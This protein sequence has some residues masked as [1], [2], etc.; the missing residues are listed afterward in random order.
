[1]PGPSNQETSSSRPSHSD[2]VPQQQGNVTDLLKDLSNQLLELRRERDEA[3][4]SIEK[5]SESVVV[6]GKELVE[7][8]SQVTRV[9]VPHIPNPKTPEKR[10]GGP[11]KPHQTRLKRTP[12]DRLSREMM[13]NLL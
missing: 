4:A 13:M 5:L 10:K 1:M 6:L 2:N 8:K 11:R 7:I 3:M 9:E 12:I